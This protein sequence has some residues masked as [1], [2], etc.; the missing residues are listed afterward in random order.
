M[1]KNNANLNLQDRDNQ[2]AL[3]WSIYKNYNINLDKLNYNV[4]CI[5]GINGR[6]TIALLLIQA[7]A[8]LDM[9]DRNGRTALIRGIFI[10]QNYSL[11]FMTFFLASQGGHYNVTLL[12]IQANANLN[13][14]DNN[15]KTALYYGK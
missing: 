5:A 9:V 15:L 3:I 6:S 10:F 14:R 2:T 8:S 7:N 4:F 13:Q 12:L 1:I 11:H